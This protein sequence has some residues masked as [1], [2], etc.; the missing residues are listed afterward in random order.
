MQYCGIGHLKESEI[1]SHSVLFCPPGGGHSHWKVVW[2]RAVLK[3]PFSGQILAPETHLF[4]PFPV[5]SPHLEFYEKILHFKTIFCRFLAPETQILAKIRSRDPSSKPKNQFRRPNFWKPGWHVPTQ[6]LGD[7]LPRVLSFTIPQCVNA[8]FFNAS[9]W[10]NCKHLR[11]R[12]KP[13]NFAQLTKNRV[14]HISVGVKENFS[15]LLPPF[16]I[17]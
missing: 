17:Y 14:A 9:Y 4:T 12:V 1:K 10:E 13:N 11:L 6:I 7:Y 16:I 8:I 15:Q 5:R 3:T 2:G